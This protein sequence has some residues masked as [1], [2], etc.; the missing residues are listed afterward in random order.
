MNPWRVAA[1]HWL[2]AA[3]LKPPDGL[4]LPDFIGIGAQK[5]GTSWLHENLRHHPDAFLPQPKELHYFDNFFDRPLEEYAALFAGA[6][7]RRKGE[8]T[9]AYGILPI[10]RIRYIRAVMPEARIVFLLRNPI[11]RAWSHAIMALVTHGGR[12]FEEIPPREFHDHFLSDAN[13]DR[14][15]YE[16]IWDRWTNIF[17]RQ[18]LYYGFFEDITARPLELLREICRHIGLRDDVDWQ[19]FPYAQKVYTGPGIAIPTQHYGFL[20][21]LYWPKI[22]GLRRCFGPRT[23]AWLDS[24]PAPH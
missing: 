24:I 22:A 3:G 8:I 20:R 9:P 7:S 2:Y 14:G 21:D 16:A 4:A 5:A 13:Q 23:A 10:E 15:D 11:E 12:R 19:E 17:P 6:G 18:Q 1:R